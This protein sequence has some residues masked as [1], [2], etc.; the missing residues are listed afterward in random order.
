MP[1][2]TRRALVV[3]DVQNEYVDGGLLIEYPPVQQ[4]L[5]HIGRAMDAA[6]AA[7]VPVVVVQNFAPPSSPLFARGSQ[8]AQLHPVVA[9]RARDHH[10]EK[11]LPSAFAGT[12]LERWLADN[13]I[14]TLTLVGYMTHNCVDSTAKHALHAGFKVE[15]LHDA[16]G[17]VP[18][19]NRAGFA[20]AETIHRSFSI[21][22]QS[23]FAAVLGTQ[24]WVDLL[25]SGAQ[26]ERDSI[27]Q[28]HLRG[29]QQASG[30]RPDVAKSACRA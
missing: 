2:S 25:Q 17:S 27:H 1:A 26:P 13:G 3:I 5:A 12:D 28:S 16:S 6:R 14:D 8:G 7:G 19:A 11:T 21:V 22:L 15:F 30:H 4:S 23:R 18:Y 29:L 10:L 24:E 9:T 20:S